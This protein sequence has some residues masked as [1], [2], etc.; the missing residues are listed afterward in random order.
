M[1]QTGRGGLGSRKNMSYP[2]NCFT[3]DIFVFN[4]S[5]WTRRFEISCH[6]NI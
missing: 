6:E 1:E 3:L 2:M 4:Q 5:T